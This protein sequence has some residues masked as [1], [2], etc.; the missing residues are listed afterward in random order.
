MLLR[1]CEYLL[2]FWLTPITLYV[3]RDHMPALLLPIMFLFS[4]YCVV[5]LWQSRILHKQI[6]LIKKLS[7]H[8]LAEILLP[9]LSAAMILM[10][11]VYIFIPE[12]LFDLP[13]NTPYNWLL[14][15]LLYPIVSV[16]PQEIIFRSFF[17][18]RYRKL[19]LSDNRRWLFSSISFGMAHMFYA[20][21]LAVVMSFFGGLL[22]G[23]RFLQSEKN[24]AVVVLEHSLWGM[25]L[26]TIGL[27]SYFVVSM[28]LSG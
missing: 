10:T 16:I 8:H 24:I 25:M 4:S 3:F 6:Q 11:A 15:I 2:L 17:F 18:H 22:F 5:R 23:Y 21:W 26:F 13:S 7:R 28:P 27:S 12:K 20:N 1:W 14:L 19:F 9:F